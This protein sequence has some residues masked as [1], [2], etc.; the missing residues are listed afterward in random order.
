MYCSLTVKFFL[1]FLS[2]CSMLFSIDGSKNSNMVLILFLFSFFPKVKP[3][4]IICESQHKRPW[5]NIKAQYLV[6]PNRPALSPTILS[7]TPL[8]WRRKK[9]PFP[10]NHDNWHRGKQ[11]QLGLLR[12]ESPRLMASSPTPGTRSAFLNTATQCSGFKLFVQCVELSL[13]GEKCSVGFVSSFNC[14]I[15]PYSSL[16]FCVLCQEIGCSQI[17][18]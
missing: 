17:Q 1:V 12:H 16:C 3:H 18:S 11:R 10:Q 14:L 5:L 9:I 2:Y 13:L 15:I 8:L 4:H 7:I 6:E